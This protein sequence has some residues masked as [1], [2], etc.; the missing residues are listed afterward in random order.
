MNPD[1]YDFGEFSQIKVTVKTFFEIKNNGQSDLI[2][3]RLETSCGCTLASIVYQDQE[4]PKFNMPGHGV[5]EEI[6]DWQIAISSGASAQLKVYYDPNMHPEFRGTATRTI[7]IFSNDPID[8]QK[9]VQ[10]ELNQVD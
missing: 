1:S 8:F 5:N 7:A 9:E 2:I 3:E 10:I 6:G 4:G